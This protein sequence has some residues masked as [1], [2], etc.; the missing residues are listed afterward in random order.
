MSRLKMSPD[1][2]PD[3]FVMVTGLGAEGLHQRE[4]LRAAV[5]EVATGQ[6]DLGGRDLYR[7][8][9]TAGQLRARV[10]R[11]DDH[12]LYPTFEKMLSFSVQCFSLLHRFL[13]FVWPKT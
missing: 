8:C 2:V 5:R 11:Q 12:F 10:P 9:T 13:G 7:S 6:P 4:R 1:K 3:C